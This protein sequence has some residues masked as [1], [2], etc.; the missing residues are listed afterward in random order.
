MTDDG[1]GF[2]DEQKQYLEAFLRGIAARHGGSAAPGGD[3]APPDIHRTAQDRFLAAGKKLVPEEEA[4]RKSHPLDMWD[5]LVAEAAD[6]RFP[7]GIDVFR[8]KFFGLFY[9]APAQNAFMCRL[10]IPNGILAAHQLRGLADDRRT[11]TRGGYA[12]VTTRAN[13]QLREITPQS[14]LEVL[15]GIQDAGPDLA[16]RRRRQ[17]PQHHRQPDRRHRSAGAD[18]HAAAGARAAPLHP[19]SPRA[20]RPAAQIQHRLRRRRP[21]RR[22]GGH[23]RYRLRRSVRAARRTGVPDGVYFRLLLGGITGHGDFARDTGV[24]LKP[25]ECLP[26]AIAIVRVFIANGDRTDRKRA[27]LKYLLEAWGLEKFIAEVER[28]LGRPLPRHA[29]RGLCGR[30]APS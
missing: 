1:P 3:A 24:L 13:L 7:K 28:E 5:E 25:E 17:H 20:L 2:S 27:R 12:D 16:R 15:S 11:L 4:K 14:I 8:H 10:R 18:R 30:A 6:G 19:Q 29:A 21:D 26:V 9:V 22:A 23:Q